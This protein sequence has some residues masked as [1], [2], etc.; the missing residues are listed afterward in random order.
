[1]REGLSESNGAMA[2]R[3]WRATGRE[4]RH[5]GDWDGPQLRVKRDTG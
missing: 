1:V 3:L 2:W 4:E 5:R